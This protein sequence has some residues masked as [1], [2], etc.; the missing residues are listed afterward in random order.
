[1]KVRGR[2]RPGGLEQGPA[3]PCSVAICMATYNPDPVLFRRQV[4]SI[5]AQ[6]HQ[7]WACYIQ[8]DASSPRSFAALRK[9]LAA[10]RRFRVRRNPRNLGF[11]RNFEACLRRVGTDF[12]YVATADQDDVWYPDK[13]ASLVRALEAAPGAHLVYSDMRITDRG[14]R[15]LHESYFAFRRNYHGHVGDLLIAN[16]V[17]GAASL[18]RRGLL[19]RA[20][21]F[22]AS[23]EG[24]FHDQWIGCVA[25]VAGGLAYVERPLYDYV[26]HSR[27][28]IGHSPGSPQGPRWRA[29]LGLARD[30]LRRS[31][32]EQQREWALTW[33][34]H[35]KV[36]ADMARA[37]LERFP[38]ASA[39]DRS[40]LRAAARS[41][42]SV[43]G[44]L[45]EYLRARCKGLDDLG[46]ARANLRCLL[47]LKLASLRERLGRA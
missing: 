4:E 30:L 33:L 27:N 44:A 9:I 19:E 34:P 42:V 46:M 18:F 12:D 11:Y 39:R 40:R 31:C 20:V 10:D 22:P 24:F 28:I 17:A 21:P 47:F 8:D 15:V 6:S 26:Q 3:G 41:T 29:D 14:R 13:V 43:A 37:L 36:K 25:Q 35:H 16:T 5:R 45:R 1:L 38:Q 23:G 7:A 32:W 2:V